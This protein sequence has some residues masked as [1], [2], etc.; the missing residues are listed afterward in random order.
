MLRLPFASAKEPAGQAAGE[1]ARNAA[2]ARSGGGRLRMRDAV[3]SRAVV[4]SS[5]VSCSTLGASAAQRQVCCDILRAIHPGNDLSS[6]T[7]RH[8][9]RRAARSFRT[10]IVELRGGP[11]RFSYPRTHRL[12]ATHTSR[13]ADCARPGHP[14]CGRPPRGAD[15]TASPTSTRPDHHHGLHPR[16]PAT[17]PTSVTAAPKILAGRSFPLRGIVL[18]GIVS[19]AKFWGAEALES[20]WR[21]SPARRLSS[22]GRRTVSR[23]S[24]TCSSQRRG[25]SVRSV[26]LLR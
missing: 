1:P 24:S 16:S 3:I 8:G 23:C 6:G 5:C 18:R 22:M 13:E 14:C 19:G 11:P 7:F 25:F 12:V 17:V 10:P 26:L 20:G 2:A 21:S 9:R 15:A 4:C